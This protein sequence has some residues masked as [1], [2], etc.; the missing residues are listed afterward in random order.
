MGA[1][2]LLVLASSVLI[3]C[4]SVA[5]SPAVQVTSISVPSLSGQAAS[6]D[7]TEIDQAAHLLY[8]ADRTDV[9]VDVF[10][11]STNH[12]AF[13]K[14]I[15]MP[16]APNGLALAPDLGRLFVGTAAG[17]VETV[18]IS[19]TSKTAGTVVQELQTAG[20]E[21]DLMDYAPA[22]HHLY[23]SNGPEGTIAN[24]DAATGDISSV[25]NVG[26]ALE[27]PRFDSANGL[28][29]VTSPDIG[30]IVEIDPATGSIKNKTQLSACLPT[31]LAINPK[32]NQAVIAC[33]KA[34]YSYDIVSRKPITVFNQVHGVDVV[35]Y[36]AMADRFLVAAP[37]NRPHS[38]VALFGGSPIDYISSVNTD[39]GGNSAAY[40]E[41][42]DMVYTPDT[43][44]KTAGLAAFPAPHGGADLGLW[45]PYV[46]G[47]AVLLAVSLVLLVVVGRHA[48][49]I[50]RPETAEAQPRHR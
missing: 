11:V 14:T 6:F 41:A 36:D 9:G 18:D 42:H 32:S 25:I 13:V 7:V 50:H 34:V 47:L 39:A 48:D 15:A 22:N 38:A 43:R 35:K 49:P 26:N 8:V 40:D 33:D 19:P 44:A 46:G 5:G 21:V 20:K 24:I 45:V 2:S 10:D 3:A 4:S 17:K 37:R 1:W 31:G 27:Q 30:S 16:D 12:A 29:Y 23:A 28:L